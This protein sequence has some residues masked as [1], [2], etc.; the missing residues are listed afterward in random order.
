M[1]KCIWDITGDLWT[2]MAIPNVAISYYRLCPMMEGSGFIHAYVGTTLSDSVYLIVSN[3][4]MGN[5]W[6]AGRRTQNGEAGKL[7]CVYNLRGQFIGRSMGQVVQMPYSG[8]GLDI[9]TAPGDDSR[10]AVHYR[11]K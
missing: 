1:V 11:W 8:A 9:V 2:C 4:L 3:T 7:Y 6:H 5:T 10:A